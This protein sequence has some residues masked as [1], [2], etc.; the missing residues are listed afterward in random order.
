MTMTGGGRRRGE[1][2]ISMY[3]HVCVRVCPWCWG[4]PGIYDAGAGIGQLLQTHPPHGAVGDAN[5][6]VAQAVVV[7]RELLVGAQ[8]SYRVGSQH[9]G[10]ARKSRSATAASAALLPFPGITHCSNT[11]NHAPSSPPPTP[12]CIV[13]KPRKA[14]RWR[15][16]RSKGGRGGKG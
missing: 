16:E 11:L 12:R 6:Q 14:E 9:G 8:V 1:N 7:P 2:K 4:A 13:S 3:A 15:L 5:A 10:Y